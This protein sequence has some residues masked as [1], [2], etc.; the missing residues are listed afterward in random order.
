MWGTHPTLG[1]KILKR[2]C[3]CRNFAKRLL[4]KPDLKLLQFWEYFTLV[5]AD[6]TTLKPPP[7]KKTTTTT[8]DRLWMSLCRQVSI[9]ECLLLLPLLLS[10]AEALGTRPRRLLRFRVLFS[11]HSSCIT[12]MAIVYV[13]FDVSAK[14]LKCEVLDV[15]IALP[16][17]SPTQSRSRSRSQ[18]PESGVRERPTTASPWQVKNAKKRERNNIS[19]ATVAGPLEN[20]LKP[21]RRKNRHGRSRPPSQ[22]QYFGVRVEIMGRIVAGGP[23]YDSYLFFLAHSHT[24]F[25]RIFCSNWVRSVCGEVAVF[26]STTVAARF[27][28]RL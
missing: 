25:L 10:D 20:Q 18:G 16:S 11:L 22:S 2:S 19:S 17:P 8:T 15:L 27:A 24:H 6:D 9:C 13:N 3:C 26:P 5:E 14:V 1:A 21:F 7:T 23:A 4:L 28:W 12:S